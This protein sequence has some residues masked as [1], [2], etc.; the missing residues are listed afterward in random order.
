MFQSAEEETLQ[1]QAQL[2]EEWEKKYPWVYSDDPKQGMFCKLCQKRGNAPSTARGAWTT[3]G[4]QDWN[5]ATEQ[6][7]EHSQSKCHRDAVI[8]ARMAEQGKEQSVLQLQCSAAA[9]EAEERRAKN[10][11][12][13]LKLLRS[14]YFL[15]KNCLPLTTTFDPLVQLQIAN[16]D[17]FL[18]QHVKEGPQNAQ[19]TSKFSAVMLL[20]AINSWLDRKLIESLK[21]RPYFSV[22]ADEC[23]DISTTE[24]L[25]ICC[26]WIV[27]GKPEEHFLTV[28]TYVPK[29]LPPFQMQSAPSLSRRT[30]TIVI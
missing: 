29:M 16:G 1:S 9:K 3:R 20:E 26:R 6:L 8:H 27:N 19:Y 12:I 2:Q 28:S 22:L 17:E 23:V 7:K 25:S 24:E 5:H 10:R 15:A 14:I 11:N 4:I 21:S 13:E 30:W 18:Q